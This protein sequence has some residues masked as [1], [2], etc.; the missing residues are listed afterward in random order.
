MSIQKTNKQLEVFFLAPYMKV[1]HKMM[2][3][4]HRKYLM[5]SKWDL[6][7][8]L[9]MQ[10][11]FFEKFNIWSCLTKHLYFIVFE[12]L[13][14]LFLIFKPLRDQDFLFFVKNWGCI[15][16]LYSSTLN[17]FKHKINHRIFEYKGFLIVTKVLKHI[18]CLHILNHHLMIFCQ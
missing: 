1:V 16:K 17:I 14:Y 9:R 15:K 10:I 4:V 2:P 7:Q 18:K 5:H 11:W 3:G 8:I 13:W 12:S 6:S